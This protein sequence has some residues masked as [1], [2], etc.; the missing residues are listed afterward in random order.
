M[1]F[2]CVALGF[3]SQAPPQVTAFQN[4]NEYSIESANESQ[5]AAPSQ[6][7]R[8][9]L[10]YTRYGWQNVDYWIVRPRKEIGLDRVHPIT[11]GALMLFGVLALVIWSADEVEINQLF[12]RKE[13][14]DP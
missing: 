6:Q 13:A 7:P 10:Q 3:I 5:Q 8:P 2:A 9:G 12:G 4:S 11:V 14:P 1:G